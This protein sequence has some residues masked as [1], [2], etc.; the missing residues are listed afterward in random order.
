MLAAKDAEM[1]ALAEKLLQKQ[2]AELQAKQQK[3]REE[4]E[5][6]K[7]EARR[8][9]ELLSKGFASLSN[10]SSGVIPDENSCDSRSDAAGASSRGQAPADEAEVWR[11]LDCKDDYAC[12]QLKPGAAALQVKAAFRRLALGLHPDKCSLGGASLA[13]Q[14]ITTAY[15]NLLKRMQ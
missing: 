7:A 13:F 6:K 14:R 2:I 3:A 9:K 5:R 8:R 11:V 10:G 12:L 15:H 1:K 4:K